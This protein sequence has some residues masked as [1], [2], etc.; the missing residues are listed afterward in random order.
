[1]IKEEEDFIKKQEEIIKSTNSSKVKRLAKES[2]DFL[3]KIEKNRKNE[4]INSQKNWIE[5]RRHQNQIKFNIIITTATCILAFGVFLDFFFNL[6]ENFD[7]LNN[8]FFIILFNIYII[9]IILVIF[10]MGRSLSK[11]MEN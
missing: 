4:I 8:N 10:I 6:I 11:F 1:M 3:E 2:I 5:I 9:A 7:K